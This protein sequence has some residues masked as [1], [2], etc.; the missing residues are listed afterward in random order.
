VDLLASEELTNEDRLRITSS[1]A[2]QQARITILELSRLREEAEL[3]A[4][5]NEESARLARL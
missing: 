4:A 1:I 5:I 3:R 2:L